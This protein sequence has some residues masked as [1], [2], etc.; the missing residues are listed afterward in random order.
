MAKTPS[1]VDIETTMI[2]THQTQEHLRKSIEKV[3]V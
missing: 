3:G 2:Y 1:Q